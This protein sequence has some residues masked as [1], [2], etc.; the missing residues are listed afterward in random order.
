MQ[1][2]NKFL[3]VASD[4]L[5]ARKGLLPLLGAALIIVNMV[6]Q[7]IPGAGWL[8]ASNLFLHLGILLAI[9]GF[10]LAWAL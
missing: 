1:R 7:F 9:V 6:L 8:E 5:A 3:D 2:F 10:M 4:F